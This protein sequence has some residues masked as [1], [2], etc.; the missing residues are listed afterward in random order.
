MNAPLGRDKLSTGLR[1]LILR[2]IDGMCLS[3]RSDDA[4]HELRLS[5]KRLRAWL[6]LLREA[7]GDEAYRSE[8]AA[9]RDLGRMFRHRRDSHVLVET[10]EKLGDEGDTAFHPKEIAPLRRVLEREAA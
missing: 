6:R 10:L 7:M 5:A 2:E 1:R 9:I 8:N 3:L 4:V